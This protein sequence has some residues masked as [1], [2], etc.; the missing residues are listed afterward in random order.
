MSL[1]MESLSQI[2]VTR[3]R[4]A[5][6][7]IVPEASFDDLGLDSLSQVELAMAIEKQLGVKITDDELDE[8]ESIGD[9]LRFSQR[10]A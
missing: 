8:M 6:D 2:L 5:D 9:I 10:A 3:F 7:Q 4:V 1:N